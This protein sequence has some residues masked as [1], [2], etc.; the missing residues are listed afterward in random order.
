M[1]YKKFKVCNNMLT[2]ATKK[3]LKLW[4]SITYMESQIDDAILNQ[5]RH[6]EDKEISMV[7]G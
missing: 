6:C 4:F 2:S 5:I 1:V 3:E 7:F